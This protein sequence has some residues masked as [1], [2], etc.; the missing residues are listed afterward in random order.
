MKVNWPHES[1]V[2]RG[3][4]IGVAVAKIFNSRPP[5]DDKLAWFGPVLNPIKCMSIALDRFCLIVL[6]VNLTAVVLSN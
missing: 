5:V 2:R 3:M 6:L 1:M 4:M